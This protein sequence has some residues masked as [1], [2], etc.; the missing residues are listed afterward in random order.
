MAMAIAAAS[1]PFAAGAEVA[2]R[3]LGNGLRVLVKV[4]GRAPVAVSQLWYMVG[5][6]DEHAGLTGI[7]H[8]LEH[9]MFKGTAEHPGDAFSRAMEVNGIQQ[10][11]FTSR[12]ATVYH[13]T[14][15]KDRLGL[16]LELEADRMRNLVFS[17]EEFAK[18]L[19]VVMEE[20]RWRVEDDPQSYT[21]EVANAVAFHASP[22]RHPVVG[23]SQDL[24]SLGLA[25]VRRWYEDWYAPDNA[26][27]VVVGD[28]VAEEVFQLAERHFADIP[29]S[30][31]RP[32]R[33]PRESEQQGM[34]RVEVKR[35]AEQPLLLMYFKVPSLA[36]ASR[37][38][39]AEPWEPYA[40]SVLSDLLSGDSSGRLSKFLVRG[41][42]VAAEAWAGYDLLARLDTV[43][44]FA[45]VPTEGHDVEDLEEALMEQIGRLQDELAPEGELGKIKVNAVAESLYSRDSIYY[46]AILIGSLES[47]GLSH[48]LVDQY[49]DNIRA[50][51]AEQVRQVAKK[52][53]VR[54]RLTVAWLDPQPITGGQRRP[55]P[56][57]GRRH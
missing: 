19:K 7:S 33:V 3:E 55:P 48:E 6:S 34:R 49:P 31:A 11:A 38:G 24:E 28:V 23:T 30:R 21:Y 51:T 41:S 16:V 22:Y 1:L 14:L 8:V 53:L 42:G 26:M 36:S 54:D 40:L 25:E 5:G 4:D 15:A 46:Q 43:F 57:S 50:V 29:P 37:D 20:R 13:Q 18:E 52:Y 56:A 44:Y 47:K 39:S 10:N 2:E 27:L 12:D 32:R 17:E 9:M 35:P 45:A